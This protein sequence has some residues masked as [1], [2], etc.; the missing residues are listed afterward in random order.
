MEKEECYICNKPIDPETKGYWEW[1]EE[2][3]HMECVLKTATKI[4]NKCNYLTIDDE[5]SCRD[6]GGKLRTLTKKD[7]DKLREEEKKK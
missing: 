1:A 2:P 7:R 5:N 3:A 6:C 4:C